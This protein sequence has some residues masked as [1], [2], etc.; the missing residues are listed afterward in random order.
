M[1]RAETVTLDDLVKNI[2]EAE[3]PSLGVPDAFQIQPPFLMV[4]DGVIPYWPR[5]NLSIKLHSASVSR[6]FRM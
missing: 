2:R 3:F 4:G 1:P 6:S 5:L